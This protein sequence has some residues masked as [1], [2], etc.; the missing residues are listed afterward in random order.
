MARS[1]NSPTCPIE[2]LDPN[3]L[4]EEPIVKE[5]HDMLMVRLTLTRICGDPRDAELG[6]ALR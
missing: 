3:M 6:L 2:E 4:M 1:Y 5:Y